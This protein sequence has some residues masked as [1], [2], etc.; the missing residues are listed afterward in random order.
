[1]TAKISSVVLDPKREGER[2]RE[3]TRGNTTQTEIDRSA[4]KKRKKK[5][6]KRRGKWR[7]NNNNKEQQNQRVE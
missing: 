2:G 6:V 4:R 7:Q 5:T 3:R 1:M